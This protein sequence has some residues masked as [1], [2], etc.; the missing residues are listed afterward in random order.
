MLL[1]IIP[2]NKE[3]TPMFLPLVRQLIQEA[4][5]SIWERPF[6]AKTVYV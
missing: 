2:S 3:M 5:R 4:G 1:R 6:V